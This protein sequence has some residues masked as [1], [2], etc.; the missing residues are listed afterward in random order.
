MSGLSG[1]EVGF[2]TRKKGIATPIYYFSAEVDGIN[3]YA[4]DLSMIGNSKFFDKSDYS[5]LLDSI[6]GMHTKQNDSDNK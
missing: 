6:N 5:S 4:N 3:F 1:I 2:E